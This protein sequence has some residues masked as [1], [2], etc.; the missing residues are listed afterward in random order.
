MSRGIRQGCPVSALLFIFVIEILVLK[1]NASESIQGFNLGQTNK[2]KCVQHADDCTF[3]LKNV[4]SLKD[5]IRIIEKFGRMSGTKLNIEKTEGILLGPLKN[6]LQ[7]VDGI[8]MTNNPV[9]SLGIFLGHDKESNDEK[10]WLNKLKEFEKILDS[11]RIRKLTLFGKCTVINSLIVSKLLYLFTVLENP[12]IE[13]IKKL[14]KIIYNFLWGKRERIKRKSLVRSI[15]EGGLGLIDV[16]CK[17]KSVKAGWIKRLYN[18]ESSLRKYIEDILKINR[19]NFEYLLRSNIVKPNDLN[20][21]QK[22]PKFYKEIICSFNECKSSHVSRKQL[23][24]N[25]WLNNFIKCKEKPLFLESWIKSGILYVKDMFTIDGIKDLN[26]ITENLKSKRNYLCEYLIIKNAIRKLNVD[27][28]NVNNTNIQNPYF[29]FCGKIKQPE[30]EKSGFYYKILLSKKTQ[31]PIM[32]A[33]WSKEFNISND[34][35][36]NIYTAKII[37]AF[38]KQIA[39]FN[40]KLL[41]N[42]L[43][44]NY[45]VNKWNKDVGKNCVSCEQIENIEHLI[46]GCPDTK[47]IWEKV[48]EILK[49]NITW[50]TIAVGFFYEFTDTTKTL[51]NVISC[52]GYKIYKYKMKCRLQ[53]EIPNE[54][55]LSNVLKT[56][57]YYYYFTTVSAK[58]VKSSYKILKTLADQL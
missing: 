46:Y 47:R 11:W 14:N 57:L 21:L 17:L 36:K 45:N 15:N 58:S 32:E 20:V 3:P 23:T 50:K 56:S 22:F 53:N 38:D 13:F 16:E 2:I 28:S 27:Y 6:S 30:H 12:N 44:C 37:N 35:W 40:Y 55:A 39:E 42:Q 48:S 5:A 18:K 49:L 52:V 26:D 33:K 41:H 54:N 43:N 10:N 34:Q 9:K 19:I 7:Y 8:K 4:E 1:I 31:K 24:E 51:N 25:L 29:H